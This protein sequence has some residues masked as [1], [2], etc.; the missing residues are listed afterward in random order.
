[1]RTERLVGAFEMKTTILMV[2]VPKHK[3][4]IK[5]NGELNKINIRHHVV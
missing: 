3:I 2:L 4:C 5:L 1:M